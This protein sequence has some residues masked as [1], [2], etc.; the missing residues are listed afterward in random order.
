MTIPRELKYK[1]GR[2]YQWPVRE[3]REY[4]KDKLEYSGI[5]LSSEERRFD[6]ISGRSLELDINI[7]SPEEGAPLYREFSIRFAED[8]EHYIS[9]SYRPGRSLLTIDRSHSGQSSNITSRRSSRV[10]YQ[11][12]RLSLRILIDKW[13]AEVFVNGG[14]QVISTTF[15]TPIEAE[16]ITFSADGNVVLDMTAYRLGC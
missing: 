9:L 13:S 14:E 11:R 5:S 2:L 10:T 12:G 15:Y 8:D 1:N 4:R 16:G 3:L 7:A 6:G